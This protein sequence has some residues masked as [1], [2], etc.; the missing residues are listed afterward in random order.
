MVISEATAKEDGCGTS[1]YVRGKDSR[2]EGGVGGEG[3]GG[4]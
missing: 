2:G 4:Y 1:G 3:K